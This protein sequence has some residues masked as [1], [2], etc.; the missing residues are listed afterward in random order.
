[1]EE[2]S[3]LVTGDTVSPTAVEM[4]KGEPITATSVDM[5]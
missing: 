2:G 3:G 5:V 4:N 1:M